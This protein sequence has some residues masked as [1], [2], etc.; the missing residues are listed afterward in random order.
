VYL[1]QKYFILN[2]QF[3]EMPESAAVLIA[4]AALKTAL[5]ALLA[6]LEAAVATVFTILWA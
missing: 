5:L 2:V 6:I 3:F 4:I 1:I